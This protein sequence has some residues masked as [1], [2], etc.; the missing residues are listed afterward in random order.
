MARW[1]LCWVEGVELGRHR[2]EA[3]L[4]IQVRGDNK[5]DNGLEA[6]KQ[7]IAFWIIQR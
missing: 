2:K 5:C 6:A 3:I 1:S 4:V 7:K